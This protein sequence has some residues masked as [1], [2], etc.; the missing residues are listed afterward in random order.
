MKKILAAVFSIVFL[1]VGCSA[2]KASECISAIREVS[3]PYKPMV[4]LTFDDGPG[5]YTEEILDVFAKYNARASFCMVGNRIEEYSDVVKRVAEEQHEIVCH[6][7]SHANL[8]KLGK[9]KI[10]KQISQTNE[11]IKDVTGFEPEFFRPPYGKVN[12]TV[13]EAV[14]E[15]DTAVISW[16]VDTKDWENHSKKK[17]LSIIKK[18]TRDGSVILCHDLYKETSEAIKDAVPWLID[19][20]YELV[21]V[22]ELICSKKGAIEAGKVYRNAF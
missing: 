18:E 20:G 3:D 2:D 9:K 14:L 15:L 22:S 8:T 17:I 6:S 12:D 4:A 10:I 7:W 21:T 19:E 5:D 11:L 1:T 13:L 16:S